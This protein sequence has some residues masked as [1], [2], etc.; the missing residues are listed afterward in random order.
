MVGLREK[1][2]ITFPE[3]MIVENIIPQKMTIKLS[4]ALVDN[5]M[6]QNNIFNYHPLREC[7][8]YMLYCEMCNILCNDLC[9]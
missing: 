7:N 6:P 5:H 4:F 3:M 9:K 2:R 8:I 1:K